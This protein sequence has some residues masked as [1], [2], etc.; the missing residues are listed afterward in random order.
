MRRR[1]FV[2]REE[3]HEGVPVV[4]LFREGRAAGTILLWV[5]NF[6]NLLN[7]YLLA[8]WLP[9]VVTAWATDVRPRCSLGTILQV[10]GTPAPFGL[11]WLVAASDSS[12]C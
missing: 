3:K 4:H 6:M 8:S 12:R 7:L 5:V 10:G 1:E 2:V 11:A 9:T